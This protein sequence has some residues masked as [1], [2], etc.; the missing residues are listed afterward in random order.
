MLKYARIIRSSYA[1]VAIEV[2][3]T[4]A[5]QFLAYAYLLRVLSAETLGLW[6][7]INSLLSFSRVADFWSTGLPSFVAQAR[8]QRDH[9]EASSFAVTAAIVGVFGYLILAVIFATIV[10]AFAY[11]V[12]DAKHLPMV[13]AITPTMAAT[14]WLTSVTSITLSAFLGFERPE[15]KALLTISASALFLVLAVLMAPVHGVVGV[16]HAQFFQVL[17]ATVC[18]LTLFYLLIMRPHKGKFQFVILTRMMRFGARASL[19][20]AMQLSIEPVSRLLVSSFGGLASVAVFEI[21]ARLISTLRNVI[22][23]AGQV[24]VPKFASMAHDDV[25]TGK[26]LRE[27]ELHFILLGLFGFSLLLSATPLISILLMGQFET[28]FTWIMWILSLGWLA[29]LFSAP[30]YLLFLARRETRPLL[31]SQGT[32]L[33]LLCGMGIGLGHLAGILGTLFGI[34]IALATA[35]L[36]LWL[37]AKRLRNQESRVEIAEKSVMIILCATILGLF[38][39]LAVER[40][41]LPVGLA[42]CTLPIFANLAIT[43][44]SPPIRTLMKA[45]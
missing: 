10:S 23:S 22:A 13:D 31:L 11:L 41:N 4:A 3:A 20:G 2:V 43:I 6:V 38:F 25:M 24:V 8:G 9:G 16:V 40:A 15:I 34:S 12:V 29:N 33:L 39:I 37:C 26:A 27:I 28:S 5:L 14:F 44:L 35:S 30:A 17:T 18:S 19:I 45:I 36:Y 42:V 7:L 1:I 21:A 32:M